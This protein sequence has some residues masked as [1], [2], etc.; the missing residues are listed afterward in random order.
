MWNLKYLITRTCCW[1]DCEFSNS[2]KC[3]SC[4]HYV[5]E[6][7]AE[8]K[9]DLEEEIM[10]YEDEVNMEFVGNLVVKLLCLHCSN[11]KCNFACLQWY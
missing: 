3:C 11:K 9:F 6:R 7:H 4:H 2:I 1:E 8:E 10:S 5:C